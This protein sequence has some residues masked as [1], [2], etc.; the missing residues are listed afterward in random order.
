MFAPHNFFR[1]FFSKT[2][3]GFFPFDKKS[4]K[5]QSLKSVEPLFQS[6]RL[7]FSRTD[8]R[9]D[10]LAEQHPPLAQTHSASLRSRFYFVSYYIPPDDQVLVLRAITSGVGARFA[11]RAETDQSKKSP[12]CIQNSKINSNILI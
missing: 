8:G 12:I 2:K 5:K 7:N 4:F 9:K 3:N 1:N 6:I 11:R 10:I